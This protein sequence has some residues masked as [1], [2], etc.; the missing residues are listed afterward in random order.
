MHQLLPLKVKIWIIIG[1]AAILSGVTSWLGLHPLAIGTIVGVVEFVLLFLLSHSWGW[2]ARIPR[3]P[4]P[5]WMALDLTGKWTGEIRSQWE[6]GSNESISAT[7]NVR[8]SWQDVVFDVETARM[9]SRSFGAIPTYDPASRSLQF[10]YFFETTPTAAS[11][12]AN[13]PQQLGS[14]LAHIKLDDA[15]HMTIRYTNER[16]LGGDIALSRFGR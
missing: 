2:I 14:A 15:N 16:G 1:L 3:L 11:A 10:R 7:V 4:R 9:R 13:P 8:Q 6:N 5:A 12:V